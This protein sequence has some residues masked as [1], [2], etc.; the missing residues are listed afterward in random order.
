MR[1]VIAMMKHETNTF[2]PIVTDWARFE[3][4]GAHFGE[5][6]Q[7]A[8]AETRMPI[9]AYMALA[10]ERGAEIVTPLAAEAMPS[11]PVREDAYERMAGLVCDAVAVGCDVALL[12]LHGAMVAEHVLDGEGELLRRV[13]D[14]WR[15]I[16][17]SRSPAIST[18]T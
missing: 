7:S 10:R 17:P 2:S 16:S 1:I 4:W 18:A 5:A 11:G 15:P 6:V 9:A 8:Y 13:R 3:A 14:G 12:D